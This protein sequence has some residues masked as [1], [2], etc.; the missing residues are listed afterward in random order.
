MIQRKQT[1]WLLLATIAAFLTL[2]FPFYT[3]NVLEPI[4][5]LK[6]FK[7][8]NAGSYGNMLITILS[9]AVGV[10]ALIT[11]FLYSDRKKQMLITG[12]NTVLSLVT[13]VLYYLQTKSFSDGAYSISAILTLIIP[14]SLIAAIIGIRSDEKLIKSVDR[15]R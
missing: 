11:I 15:L 5:N 2:K 9:V 10:I 7:L 3:G 8:L 1:L 13:I 12:V 4:T 6:T 14:I